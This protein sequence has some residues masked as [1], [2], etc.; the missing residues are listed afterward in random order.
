MGQDS[1]YGRV[2]LERGNIPD[3]EPVIV[4]RAQDRILPKLLKVYRYFCELARS[5]EHHLAAIDETAA[6]V[7]EWQSTHPTKI[8]TSDSLAPKD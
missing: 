3:D 8:P 7:K 5:P 1:K 4:F 2:T 6:T